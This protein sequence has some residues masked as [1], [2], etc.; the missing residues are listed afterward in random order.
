MAI[1]IL[2]SNYDTLPG[3]DK[4]LKRFSVF[5]GAGVNLRGVETLDDALD[6]ARINYGAVK[7]PIF[8]QDGTEI[9]DHYCVTKSDDNTPLGVVGKDYNPIHNRDAFEIA[10]ELVDNFGF[11][12]E[13]G[14]ASRG[15]HCVVDDAK[16]F[17]VL[18]GDDV[19]IGEGD[20]DVFNTFAVFRNSFDGSSGIQYRFVMQRLVCMNG[21]TR[22]L[23]G[24]KSQLWINVQHSNSMA[25][26][27]MIANEAM[28]NYAHDVD[29]IKAEANAFM[30]THLTRKEFENEII[31]MLLSTMKL[32]VEDEKESNQAK[33]T[34]VVQK[35]LSAYDAE[36][37]A[38]YNGT[39]YKAILAMTDFE[40]HME[41]MRDTQNPSIYM[42][43]TLNGMVWT[44]AIANYLVQTRHIRLLQSI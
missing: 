24:K 22:Y 6:K 5:N 18:R 35:A 30:N 33:I 9:K 15:S 26:K 39:A 41:P 44:T 34:N 4:V 25:D 21:M 36:D 23:G 8:L 19:R 29:A 38:A 11:Q 17:L 1:T 10:G 2:G 16:T 40:S 20:G 27:L 32:N 42:N 43:R 12:Y 31:P 13:A 28:R 3:R 14:G 7:S 37:T